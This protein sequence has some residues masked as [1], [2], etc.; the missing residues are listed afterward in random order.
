MRKQRDTQ[1]IM[2]F[3][4]GLFITLIGIGVLVTGII[5]NVQHNNRMRNWTE[6]QATVVG[7]QLG[8]AIPEIGNPIPHGMAW[9]TT[10]LMIFQFEYN[11][12]TFRAIQPFPRSTHNR[13]YISGSQVRDWVV[14]VRPHTIFV[15]PQALT[16]STSLDPFIYRPRDSR[17]Y[18]ILHTLF[19]TGYHYHDSTTMIA[20]TDNTFVEQI[21]RI[22]QSDIAIRGEGGLWTILI[23]IGCIV[24]V[25][26]SLLLLPAIFKR[27]RKRNNPTKIHSRADIN[28]TSTFSRPRMSSEEL[29]AWEKERRQRPYQSGAFSVWLMSVPPAHTTSKIDLIKIIREYNTS[30]SIGDAKNIVD[31]P[32]QL[33]TR[34]MAQQDAE[35]LA[36]RLRDFKADAEVR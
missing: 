36:Q 3:C 25:V 35:T 34:G 18:G 4:A 19:A 10:P 9:R 1:R 5:F 21:L 29:N 2:M 26:G 30:M 8:F 22:P 20:Y 13:Q 16:N 11:G 14:N 28:S 33:V 7:Y 6:I 23:I 17:S 24:I 32:P 27:N 12:T 15:N 31:N